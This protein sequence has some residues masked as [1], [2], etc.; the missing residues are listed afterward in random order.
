MN[1]THASPVGA[2]SASAEIDKFFQRAAA[3]GLQPRWRNLTGV[4]EFNI[5]G[6]GIW[7]ATIKKGVVTVSK[8]AGD[9]STPPTCIMSCSADDFVRLEHREGNLN[10][11]AAA[12]QEILTI[13][14]DM[15][16]AWAVLNSFV[17]NPEEARAR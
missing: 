11:Y 12:L 16:F 14:G 4:C 13:S 7:R 17:L 3:S 9:E 6:A 15:P 5:E 8:G 2:S 10:V 1:Q